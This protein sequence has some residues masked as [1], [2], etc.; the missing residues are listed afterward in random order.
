MIGNVASRTIGKKTGGRPEFVH[1]S[2]LTCLIFVA[3]CS[4]HGTP[5][6][7]TVVRDG[8]KVYKYKRGVITCP[9]G[10]HIN[11]HPSDYEKDSGFS[12]PTICNYGP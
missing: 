1:A 7:T 3:G 9:D 4:A 5:F 10:R 12:I 11:Y 8:D 2:A 6:N